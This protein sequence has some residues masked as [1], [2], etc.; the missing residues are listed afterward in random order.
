MR[1]PDSTE[2]LSYMFYYVDL[3]PI[4]EEEIE[5]G[6]YDFAAHCKEEAYYDEEL[7]DIIS[8]NFELMYRFAKEYADKKAGYILEEILEAKYIFFHDMSTPDEVMCIMQEFPECLFACG[9]M[10]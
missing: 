5:Y 2:Y 6:I 9:H 4:H 8:N 1:R 10:G 7:C 3:I